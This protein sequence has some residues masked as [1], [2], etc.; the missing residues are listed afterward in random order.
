MGLLPDTQNCG[1]R[2][3]RECRERF[4]RHRLQ[5]KPLVSG[6]SMHHGTCVTHVS[7]YMSGSLTCSDGANVPGIPGACATR[8]FTYLESGPCCPVITWPKFCKAQQIYGLFSELEV[9]VR[10][11]TLMS[12]S[13][14]ELL[15]FQ[16]CIKIVFFIVWVRYCGW[17]FKGTLWNST[18][19]VLS[20]HRNMCFLFTGENLDLRAAHKHFWNA[21]WSPFYL[22]HCLSYTV[23]YWPLLHWPWVNNLYTGGEMHGALA[24]LVAL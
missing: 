18:Q 4:Y 1:L 5:M 13:T 24:Q 8:N 21:P 22:S 9:R 16:R 17:N 14:Q 2:M 11:K 23:S 3:R 20:I 6:P 7:W 15:K 19:N 12:S 10:F